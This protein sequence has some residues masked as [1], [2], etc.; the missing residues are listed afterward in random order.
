M[1]LITATPY[2]LPRLVTTVAA[3]AMLVSLGVAATAHAAETAKPE[4]TKPPI[5]DPA[6]ALTKADVEKIIADYLMNNGKLIM[7]SV[8]N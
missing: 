6:S 3:L 7:D 8:D 1:S 4:T 5:A 2:R